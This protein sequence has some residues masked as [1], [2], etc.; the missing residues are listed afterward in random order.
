MLIIKKHLII[1]LNSFKAHFRV[2]DNFRQ[3]KAP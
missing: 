3:L 2:W 1:Y